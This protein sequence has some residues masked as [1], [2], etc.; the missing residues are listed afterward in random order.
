MIKIFSRVGGGV[1]TTDPPRGV[2][3]GAVRCG[4]SGNSGHDIECVT[5]DISC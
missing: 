4:R 3:K 1:K 2:K 5:M